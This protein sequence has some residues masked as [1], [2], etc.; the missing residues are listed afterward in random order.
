VYRFLLRPKWLGFLAACVALAII[1]VELGFWQLRRLDQRRAMN[2]RV[3]AGRIADP[4]PPSSLFG[5]GR[6]P[7][8]ASEYR[9]VRVTGT[10]DSAHEYLVRGQTTDDGVG[11]NVLTPL[12]TASGDRVLIARGWARYSDQGATVAPS[13]P[14]PPTGPVTVVGRVRL[15]D[16]GGAMARVGRFQTV[17]QVDPSL[18]GRDLGQ[19]VFGGYVELVKQTPSVTGGLVLIPEPEL[20][21]GP[22]LAYAVQWFLFAGM[23]FVGYGMYARREVTGEPGDNPVP[24]TED[25]AEPARAGSITPAED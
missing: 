14:A 17:T 6:P 23:L 5:P 19:P 9:S 24:A 4:V 22:H 18:I 8:L 16:F 25:N 15:P 2:A 11:V 7:V 21:E 1:F 13:V 12:V 3:V 20:T 10:Y